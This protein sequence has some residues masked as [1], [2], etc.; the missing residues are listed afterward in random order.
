MAWV[1][2]VTTAML[3]SSAF[4]AQGLLTEPAKMP[5]V[6]SLCVLSA[7]AVGTSLF[8]PD[9]GRYNEKKALLA[10]LDIKVEP[11]M[12]MTIDNPHNWG[13]HQMVVMPQAIMD[14]AD[15]YKK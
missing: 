13:G 2:I 10:E 1:V 15:Y 7:V 12:I 5:I 11:A 14:D 9:F 3:I 4:I 8:V 6:V